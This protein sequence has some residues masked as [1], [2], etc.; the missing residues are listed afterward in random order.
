MVV[1]KLEHA[2]LY[3]GLGPRFQ[4]A[5]EWLR[6]VDPDTLTPGERVEID[7]NDI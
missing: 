4:K 1:D 7:G 3:G 2:S 6:T 5:L